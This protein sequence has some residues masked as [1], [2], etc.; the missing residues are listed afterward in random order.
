MSTHRKVG[1]WIWLKPN[2]GFVGESNRL[3]AEIIDIDP[4]YTALAGPDPHW[5]DDPT[6]IEWPNLLTA[7]DPENKDQRW[8]LYHVGECEMLDEPQ[9]S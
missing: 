6:C 8:P 1:D 7:P 3:K 5:C 2:T 9:S 4:E